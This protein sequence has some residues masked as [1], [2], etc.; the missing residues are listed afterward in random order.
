[1]SWS[2]GIRRHAVAR[3]VALWCVA[4]VPQVVA[5]SPAEDAG[6]RIGDAI[7]QADAARADGRLAEAAR[8]YAD[9]YALTR[10]SE[11]Y[12]GT[13]VALD[14]VL[15]AA[16]LYRE[17]FKASA[18][19][20][21]LCRDSGALLDSFVEDVEGL[22]EAVPQ[23]VRDEQALVAECLEGAP[24][25]E[26]AVK[27]EP[28]V[29]VE[30]VETPP[31]AEPPPETLETT[32]EP[33]PEPDQPVAPRRRAVP[34]ALLAGGGA[35]TVVGT[36]MLVVGVPLKGRASD[37]RTE[38]LASPEYLERGPDDQAAI[39][40]ALDVYVDGERGRGVGL[41]AAGGAVMGLGVAAVIVGSVQL[42][43]GRSGRGS[44]DARRMEPRLAV[45]RG[46]LAVGAS[47]RF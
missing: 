26:P 12:R 6:Q 44:N 28:E 39:T 30:P 16:Q 10:A 35:A 8:L 19:D 37:Y 1:M 41:M 27:E 11:D 25:P 13:G 45:G 15:L 31:T 17:A 2:Q 9:A 33:E 18:Q 36:V 24:E 34:I 40:S 47:L 20:H 43:K 7:A 38:V 14:V 5:A 42:A 29:P 4:G 3:L 32:V 23:A 22:G 21:A 46:H